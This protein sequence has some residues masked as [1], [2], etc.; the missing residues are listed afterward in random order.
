MTVLHDEAIAAYAPLARHYDLL[1]A[2]YDHDGWLSGL[3]QLALAHGLA[4]R[5]LLDV[6]RD[7]YAAFLI[8]WEAASVP[9]DLQGR[10]ARGAQ[11]LDVQGVGNVQGGWD[12]TPLD[13]R[14]HPGVACR[15]AVPR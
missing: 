4:G 3:E 15:P 2:D 5:R 7:E 10:F 6:E 8:P 1:T 11:A 9:I 12:A 14:P 13:S